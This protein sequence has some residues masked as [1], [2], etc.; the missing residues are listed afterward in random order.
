[1]QSDIDKPNKLVCLLLL[2]TSV[3]TNDYA[4]FSILMITLLAGFSSLK[5]GQWYHDEVALRIDC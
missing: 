3:I 4:A 2:P 1:M 5:V